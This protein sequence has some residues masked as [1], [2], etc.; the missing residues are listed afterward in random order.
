[1]SRMNSR[2]TLRDVWPSG[3]VPLSLFK[4]FA[5]NYVISTGRLIMYLTLLKIL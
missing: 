2:A 1:M 4:D 3:R 5:M